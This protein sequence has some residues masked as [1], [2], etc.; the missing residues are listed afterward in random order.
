[1]MRETAPDMPLVSVLL[2]SYNSGAYIGEAI[3]CVL[4]QTYPRLELIVVDDGSTDDSRERIAAAVAAGAPVPVRVLHQANL[5]QAA[6]LNRA[7]DAAQGPVI[8]LMDGDDTWAPDKVPEM[9]AMMTRHAGGGV[10]QHQMDNGLG[11]PLRR[12]L[13]SGDLFGAWQRAEVVDLATRA[14][15][16][17]FNMVTSGLMF[18]R[19]VLEAIM[20]IPEVLRACPDFYLFV[21]GC[22]QGPLYSY[23]GILGVWRFHE[24]NAGK[25][26]A[27]GFRNF[28]LPVVFETVNAA[29]RDRGF[30]IRFVYRRYAILLEPY[31][32]VRDILRRRRRRDPSER[33]V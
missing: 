8:A 6:A 5:G 12:L 3:R 7:F 10:Y 20:P 22:S 1:M 16:T 30:K 11:H 4:E 2:T 9:V 33:F 26:E 21:L 29:L 23:P 27:F 14:D 19:E 24:A 15:L 18:R 25:Q 13:P 31:R 32:I 17:G 28:V